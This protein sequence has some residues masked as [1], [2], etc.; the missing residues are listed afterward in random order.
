MADSRSPSVASQVPFFNFCM[1]MERICEAKGSIEKKR[2]PLRKLISSWRE[3]HRRIHG[4]TKTTDSLFPL[5]RL[6]LPHLDKDRPAYGMKENIF[7]RYIIDV[8]S[9]GK[10]SSS[11]RKLLN[12]RHPSSSKQDSQGDFASVAY[13]VLKDRCP[14]KGSL[15]IE[16]VNKLLD[17]MANANLEKKRDNV[18]MSIQMLLRESSAKEVKWLIR[19]ILK[20]LKMGLGENSVFAVFHPD[21]LD[22][23]N[24]CNNLSKVCMDL[25]D[26]SVR[27]NEAEITIFS[28]F[29]PML[30]QW[31][32]LNQVEDLMKNQPFY[33]ETKMDGERFILHKDGDKYRYFSRGGNDFTHTFGENSREGCLTP[34]INDCFERLISISSPGQS[35]HAFWM[36]R[37]WFMTHPMKFLFRQPCFVVFDV[38]LYNG[39]KLANTPLHERLKLLETVF[40]PCLGF[41]QFVERQN[42]SSNEEVIKSLNEAIDRREE[43]L[44]VKSRDSVYKP[45][46][47]NGGGWLKIKPEYVASL[48]DDLDVVIVGGY[49]G[50]GRR[51]GM[52]SHFLC[53][54]AVP[55]DRRGEKPSQ[56]YSLCKVGSGYTMNELDELGQQLKP[57]WQPFNQAKPPKSVCF[58][59]GFKEKPDVWIEPSKSKVVQIKAAE[60]TPSEKYRAGFTL[61]FPRLECVRH[62]KSWYDCLDLS[63]LEQLLKKAE[64]KLTSRH[65]SLGEESAPAK[66]R[67][68]TTQKRAEQMRMS[69]APQFKP[70]EVSTV[71]KVSKLFEGKEFCIVTGP[72]TH[73]KPSLEKMITQVRSFGRVSWIISYFIVCRDGRFDVVQAA[74]LIDCMNQAK[75]L[76][77]Q[78]AQ[79]LHTSSATTAKF[80]E[81]YDRHGDSFTC[82]ATADSLKTVFHNIANS[83]KQLPSATITAKEIADIEQRYFP[84]STPHNLFRTCSVLNIYQ[85]VQSFL[86]VIPDCSLELTALELRCHGAHIQERFDETVTH[87]VFDDRDLSRLPTYQQIMRNRPKKHHFVTEKWVTQS[88]GNERILSERQFAPRAYTSA[89]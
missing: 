13:F 30:A 83:I 43:G 86:Q 65:T 24:T 9:L 21:A 35:I 31:S 57:H 6:L 55:S 38:L 34:K 1:A 72:A 26:P 46:V 74:W 87:V 81:E 10:D 41:L 59:P 63:G 25:H 50:V 58:T 16:E 20:E 19:I 42:A 39:K 12:Y 32:P 84:A 2:D 5:L 80:R 29:R 78:P 40:K 76:P 17:D 27:M 77:W 37:C 44:V 11:G 51:Q 75:L 61:R 62:D 68:R 73:P 36:E 54:V 64:G 79:M 56:F 23:Y 18:K 69:V 85:L 4:S 67:S 22:H 47:R 60:I 52:V 28:A 14:E 3:A 88:I 70:S 45:N 89:S 8:M 82:D 71:A 7:A 48:S 53:A 66:K 49:F 15:N 33:I